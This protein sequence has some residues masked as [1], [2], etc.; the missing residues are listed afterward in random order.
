MAKG[1]QEWGHFD[2]GTDAVTWPSDDAGAED[3]LDVAALYTLKNSG[4][5]YA[6][7]HAEMPADTSVA[8]LFR[9]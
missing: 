9:Y 5:V 2:P 8:A 7:A 6:L 4:T 3:L 1:V